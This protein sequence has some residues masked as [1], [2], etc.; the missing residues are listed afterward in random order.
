MLII[1]AAPREGGKSPIRPPPVL[2]HIATDKIPPAATCV[3]ILVAW[4]EWRSNKA[5]SAGTEWALTF[6]STSN[7]GRGEQATRSTGVGAGAAISSTNVGGYE[8]T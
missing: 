2:Q 4:S 5:A 6:D 3:F 1:T 8:S 7:S